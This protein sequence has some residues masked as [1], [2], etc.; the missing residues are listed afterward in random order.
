MKK[1]TEGELSCSYFSPASIS[2]AEL[3]FPRFQQGVARGRAHERT[4]LEGESQSG[5]GKEG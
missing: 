1:E 5:K 4:E 3:K 2:T